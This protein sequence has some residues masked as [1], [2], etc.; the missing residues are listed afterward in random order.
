MTNSVISRLGSRHGH[1]HG[2]LPACRHHKNVIVYL[3]RAA[4][5]RQDGS[6]IGMVWC[7]SSLMFVVIVFVVAFSFWVPSPWGYSFRSQAETTR[8]ITRKRKRGNGFTVAAVAATHAGWW[9]STSQKQLLR[10]VNSAD[11]SASRY[12]L[13]ERSAETDRRTKRS[14]PVDFLCYPTSGHQNQASPEHR[15][16]S[17]E[18]A[19]QHSMCA[20]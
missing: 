7:S 16:R 15:A 3:V 17:T 10:R 5:T 2:C 4:P 11:G 9:G 18:R 1:G 12:T 14:G 19:Q 20:R 8:E 13:P 6:Y